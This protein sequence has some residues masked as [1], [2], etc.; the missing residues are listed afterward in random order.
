MGNRRLVAAIIAA[1]I[2]LAAT[3]AP[4]TAA[5]GASSDAVTVPA[6]V[7]AGVALPIYAV[8]RT[9]WTPPGFS[10]TG[11]Q[12][13]AAAER[14]PEMLTLHA[15][16]HPMDVISKVWLGRSWLIDFYYRG[17]LKAEVVLSKTAHVQNVW[18]GP[19]AVAPYARGD[20]AVPFGHWWVLVPFSLLF[21]LPF[22]DLRRLL[23]W[24]LFDGLAVLSLLISYLLFDHA[25]F[26]PAVWLVYPPLL[27][28]LG[29]M[30][31]LGGIRF[32]RD[33]RTKPPAATASGS[34]LTRVPLGYLAG[35]LALL[36]IARL[37]LSF[38][39]KTVVDVGYASVIGADRIAH[40]QSLYFASAAHGDTYGPIAYL[41]YLPFE[42]LWPWHGAWDYLTSAHVASAAFDLIT[43]GGLIAL[44]RRFRDGA[45][46]LRLGL[47]FAWAWAACPFTLLAL[48]MHTNDGLVAMLSVLSL[49]AFSSP[50]GRGIVLGLAAAA[51]F[52]PAAL[53]GLYAGPEW[54]LK[55]AATCIVSFAVVV[56]AAVGLYL[57]PGGVSEFYR[58]T[59]GFQLN[60]SDVFSIW[61][62]H[63]GLDPLKIV[64][65]AGAIL[66]AALVTF[67]PKR[68][69]LT[70]V[71]ALA[72]A[73][74]VGLQL[75]AVHWFYYFAVWFIPFVV[76]AVLSDEPEADAPSPADGAI[77][78]VTMPLPERPRD[79][80]VA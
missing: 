62:L 42:R 14:D 67:V 25:T 79:L 11:A 55:R 60:R 75:P 24:R 6:S 10:S 30:L 52:A 4:S 53:L 74:T 22:L 39:D 47:V 61:A 33:G 43:I 38:L 68:R 19:Q 23:R 36:V 15:R 40:G 54:G 64:I 66:L 50:A 20:F 56:A 63:P 35:G 18:T 29:R 76:I 21:L 5:S 37:V 70:Q 28:L 1:L 48:M 32:R 65:E 72:A 57:P 34:V 8:T 73:V 31:W 78:D 58:H 49:V 41:A 13:I 80:V 3:A 26:A 46:G 7:G 45:A 12:A 17:K 51:K 16:L 27:Y 44:G 69:S 59:I 77:A 71:A 9:N 2:A